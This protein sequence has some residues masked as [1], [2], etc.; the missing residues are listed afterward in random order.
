MVDYATDYTDEEQMDHPLFDNLDRGNIVDQLQDP[1]KAYNDTM[2]LYDEAVQS[3][4]P[5]LKKYNRAIKLAKLQPT[6]GD[7]DIE[8]KDFPFEGASLVM[9]PYIL[10]AMLDFN[11]RAA[12]ELV[13]ADEVVTLKVYGRTVTIPGVEQSQIDE[14]IEETK[15]KRADRVST[16]MNYQLAEDIPFW[17]EGQDKCLMMLPC[18]GTVYKETYRDNDTGQICSD[19]LRADKVIFDMNCA[20]F[21]EAQH[22]FQDIQCNRNELIAYIRGEQKW[23]IDE[24]DLEED[25][26]Q[27]DFIKAYTYIDVDDDGIEEPYLAILDQE[28]EKIVYL[29]PNYDE[30]TVT[31]N[32]QGELIRIEEIKCYTQYRFLPDPEGGPMGLGWGILLGPMFEAINANVRQLIDAGTLANTSANSGLIAAGIGKG[33]GNRQEPGPIS[34]A[35]AQLT[36]VPMGGLNGSLRENIVQFPFAGPNA[37]LFQ[38]MEYLIN[39]ARSMTNAAVNVESNQGEAAALYLA[40]LQQ[41]LKVPNSIIM[42]VYNCAKEEFRKIFSL[43][44]KHHDSEKYNRVLDEERQYIMEADFN[45]AD[46]DIRLAADPSQGSDIERAARAEANLRLGMEQSASGMQIMNLRQATID[47]LEAIKEPNIDKLVPEPDNTPSPE[48]QMIIAEKQM[49]AEL[50][51]RDQALRENAQRLQEQKLAMESAKEMTRLGLDADEQEAEI[52]KKYMESLKIAW[53]IGMN[54]VDTIKQIEGNFID[55]GMAGK[56]RIQQ[57]RQELGL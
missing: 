23:D 45:P 46:C 15:E 7:M 52:T 28:S 19:L 33:R 44:H 16:Y 8:S 50:K 32:E 18:T 29:T 57:L 54:G 9:L 40:R 39:S 12:P 56:Q 48:M 35:M 1:S 37:T 38:L 21:D 42:R 27:F 34:V 14:A 43:N 51:Q 13:W 30:D 55:G 36:P 4:R 2:E 20:N 24:A 47:M 17:R 3:M 31:L 49:E 26:R 53:E 10:E 6:A 22:K 11:S 5:W 25:K 41:G